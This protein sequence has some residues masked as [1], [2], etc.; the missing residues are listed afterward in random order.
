MWAHATYINCQSTGDTGASSLPARCLCHT[1][2][3]PD[4]WLGCQTGRV[5]LTS[6]ADF[7]GFIVQKD[8]VSP[9][10]E[11]CADAAQNSFVWGSYGE[12]KWQKASAKLAFKYMLCLVLAPTTFT[13]RDKRGTSCKM[14]CGMTNVFRMWQQQQQHFVVWSPGLISPQRALSA[15]S[16]ITPPSNCCRSKEKRRAYSQSWSKPQN[17]ETAEQIKVLSGCIWHHHFVSTGVE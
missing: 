15:S 4:R 9:F 11:S 7:S 1:H 17:F 10:M 8:S 6:S 14:R 2:T 3:A 5:L 13:D 16:L 12:H